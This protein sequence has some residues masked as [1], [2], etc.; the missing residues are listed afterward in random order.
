MCTV[1]VQDNPQS[2]DDRKLFQYDDL[3][4]ELSLLGIIWYYMVLY[5]IIWYY[6]VLY[7]IIWYYMTYLMIW[8]R[9][10]QVYTLQSQGM[11]NVMKLIV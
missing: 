2:K 4:F 10:K 1:T 8:R 9:K 3:K 7:G 6:M 11:V 5:G